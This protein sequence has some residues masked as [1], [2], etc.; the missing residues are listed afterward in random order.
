[1]AQ[2]I[3]NSDA[4]L[5]FEARFKSDL[6]NEINE[7]T[8]TQLLVTATR[9]IDRLNFIGDQY[10]EDQGLEFPRGTDTSVPQDVKDAC[11]E[12]A[13]AL[14]NDRDIEYEAELMNQ[15]TASNEAGRLV[16]DGGIVNL[17]KVHS[18]PSQLA[19]NLLRPYLRNGSE[20]TLSRIN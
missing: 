10:D 3:T 2:Y 8:K 16:T 13:Y 1:M 7:V 6:W 9:L 17:A 12:I 18:I 19:W 5:Y 11:C 14:L 15:T 4:D 20:I